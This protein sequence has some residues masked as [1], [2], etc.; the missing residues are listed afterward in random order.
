MTED[1]FNFITDTTKENFVAAQQLVFSDKDYNP[2]SDDLDEIV[3]L[4]DNDDFEKVEAW[5]S[6]NILLSA[7]A[8]FY[9]NYALTQ[10]GKEREAQAELIIGQKILEGISLTGDGTQEN[11]YVVTRISDEQDLLEYLDEEFESQSL[12][13]NNGRFYDLNTTEWGDEIYIAIT[14]PYPKM[15]QLMDSGEIDFGF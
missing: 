13:T 14:V 2:Y 8:H 4:L 11:P 5:F 15:Q 6:V 1:F 12:V 3:E 10:L 9:K 7:R